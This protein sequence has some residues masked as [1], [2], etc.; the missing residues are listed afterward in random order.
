MKAELATY[1][2]LKDELVGLIREK[3]LRINT[4]QKQGNSINKDI[5]EKIAELNGL[6]DSNPGVKAHYN[7]DQDFKTLIDNQTT[8]KKS[9]APAGNKQALDQ[10][11]RQMKHSRKLT[12]VTDLP[13]PI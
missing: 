1:N 2:T 8:A 5:S 6:L 11:K 13:F 3:N 4:K 7:T 9:N 12:T 10:S